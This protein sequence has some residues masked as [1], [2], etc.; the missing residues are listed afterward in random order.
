MYCTGPSTVRNR[1]D[2]RSGSRSLSNQFSTRAIPFLTSFYE[3][4]YLNKVKWVPATI[5]NLL[6]PIAVAHWIMDDG[7]YAQGGLILNTQ[8]FSISCVEQLIFALNQN[9]KINRSIR[10]DSKNL[11]II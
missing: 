9:F 4:I 6:T 7:H 2:P 10:F 8:G 11:P 1:I 3:L 5:I